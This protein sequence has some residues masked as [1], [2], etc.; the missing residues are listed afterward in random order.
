MRN[1]SRRKMLASAACMA[2]ANLVPSIVRAAEPANFVDHPFK[3]GVASGD[4]LSDGFVIWTR[5]AP[6]PFDSLAAPQHPIK[7]GWQ[8]A[9]DERFRKIVREGAVIAYPENA[10]AVHA[11]IN[12]LEADREFYYRFHT[13]AEESAV[14]RAFTLPIVGSPTSRFRFAFACCQSLTD[15]HFGAYRDL[16]AQDPRLVIHTGDY[17]YEGDWVGGVRRVP[18][19][20]AFDLEGYRALYSRYKQDPALQAAHAAAPWLSIWDDH[21]VENDWGGDYSPA[22]LDPER[23]I[24]RKAAAFKAFFEHMPCESLR[25]H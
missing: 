7:V 17:I 19:P 4:P 5:L 24:K 15:G 8:I 2:A 20:E 16:V 13:G 12:G 23:F 10:H 3:L 22:G 18:V 11:E 25:D 1:L 6:V 14:G 21:E 9:K